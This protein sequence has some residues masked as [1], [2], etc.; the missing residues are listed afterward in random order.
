LGNKTQ[1]ELQPAGKPERKSWFS[2]S[3]STDSSTQQA[4]PVQGASSSSP[5]T[6]TPL[7]GE[8]KGKYAHIDGSEYEGDLKDGK[9]NG[10]GTYRHNGDVYI[11][12]FLND[13]PHGTG[14]YTFHTGESYEGEYEKGIKSG[15]GKYTY[16]DGTIYEGKYSNGLKE[17][18]VIIINHHHH[19]HYL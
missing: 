18:C 6:L 16:A 9:R 7:K 12:E 8:L 11:G 15:I 19:H 13:L 5:P 14:K 10:K 2:F 1:Q 3:K 17:A 4:P